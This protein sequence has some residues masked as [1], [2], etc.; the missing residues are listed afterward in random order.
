MSNTYYITMG[1]VV[2][3]LAIIVISDHKNGGGPRS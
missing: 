3:V 2:L 1:L